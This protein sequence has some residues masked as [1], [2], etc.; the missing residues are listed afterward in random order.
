MKTK[1]PPFFQNNSISQIYKTEIISPTGFILSFTDWGYFILEFSIMKSTLGF[2]LT[3]LSSL[4]T[5]D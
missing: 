3:G 5:W 2:K 4:E 1:H